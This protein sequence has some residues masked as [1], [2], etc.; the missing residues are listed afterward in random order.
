MKSYDFGQFLFNSSF[1]DEE[2]LEELILAAKKKHATLAT[3]ALFLRMVSLP[4]L[5]T[6]LEN[7]NATESLEEYLRTHDSEVQGKYDEMIKGVLKEGQPARLERLKESSSVWL[8]QELIDSG[9]VDSE[10]LEKLL[11][12]Y[13]KLEMS[14][15]EQ[16]FSER[17]ETLPP[18]QK[19][20]YPLAVDVVKSFHEFTSESF[21]STIILLPNDEPAKEKLLG[22]TV[23]VKGKMPVIVGLFAPEYEF[24]QF[25]QR[26]NN[27]V[28]DLN[29]AFDV[30]SEFLN[31][32]TGHLTIQFVATTGNEEEPETPRHGEV[33][34]FS[35]IKMMSDWG[36]FYL[37]V[38]NDEYFST[39]VSQPTN[40]LD[41]LGDLSQFG[42][43]DFNDDFDEKF[44]DPF[45]F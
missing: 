36:K 37:Y 15:L 30:V 22:A 26:Y 5:K 29:D 19:P 31:I 23:K 12:E 11:G 14:P 40:D 21:G 16:A 2:K 4:E 42:L 32:Y 45:D 18:E 41:E 9:T 25:A 20:D 17:Y 6:S 13:H 44:K 39:S 3:K 7:L 43:A 8:V 38:G 33:E 24:M 27:L 34:N 35:A 10:Q 28:E 1:L